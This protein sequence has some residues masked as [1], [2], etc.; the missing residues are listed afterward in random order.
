VWSL[1][2]QKPISLY[3]KDHGNEIFI[4]FL[5]R[6]IDL[7]YKCVIINLYLIN[8]SYRNLSLNEFQT[9]HII[10]YEAVDFSLPVGPDAPVWATKV[11]FLNLLF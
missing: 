5:G 9:S 1:T 10:R 7:G 4:T 6:T 8:F 11:N 3:N 2:P